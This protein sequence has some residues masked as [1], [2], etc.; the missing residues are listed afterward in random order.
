MSTSPL[1]R[2]RRAVHLAHRDD[3][4]KKAKDKAHR[5]GMLGRAK[6]LVM[7][8]GYGHIGGLAAVGGYFFVTQLLHGQHTTFGSRGIAFPDVKWAWDHLLDQVIPVQSHAQWTTTRHLIRP[9]YEGIFG[10]LLFDMIAFNPFKV[11]TKDKPPLLSRIAIKSRIIPTVYRPVTA[12]QM[13]A[14]PL[15]ITLFSLPGVAIGVGAD[16]LLRAITHVGS[17]APTLSA[18]PSVV[19]K[20][21]TSAFDAKIIGL[22]GS[23]IFARRAAKPVFNFVMRYFAQRRA[24]AVKKTYWYHPPAFR[25][26]VD[27]YKLDHFYTEL[28][29]AS[30][31]EVAQNRHGRGV[32]AVTAGLLITIVGWAGLGYYVLRFVA[33]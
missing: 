24:L 9:L 32:H 19:E 16:R 30:S 23:M 33:G 28:D 22:F 2:Y 29:G 1:E 11:K 10:G 31:A 15:T 6:L 18:H 5:I 26:L 8:L 21:Y 7:K 27:D 25:F 14:L 17:L 20:F 13:L 12:G 4:P 3:A